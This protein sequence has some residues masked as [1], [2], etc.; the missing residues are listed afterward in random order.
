MPNASSPVGPAL[1]EVGYDMTTS[2]TLTLV[3]G[4]LMNL[5]QNCTFSAVTI[6]GVP[7][8]PGTHSYA[9]LSAN[10]PLNFLPER[11]GE[12]DGGRSSRPARPRHRR[13]QVLSAWAGNAQV[14]LSWVP[15]AP[16]RPVTT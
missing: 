16:A 9:E 7:L 4:G 13:R 10:F 8:L 15:K 3:N 11:I 12:L 6:E 14:N 2:G 1:F 5:H